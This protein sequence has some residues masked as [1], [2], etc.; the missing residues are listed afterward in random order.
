MTHEQFMTFSQST[1]MTGEIVKLTV[2]GAQI[3]NPIL[4]TA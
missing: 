3:P 4:N 1:G 2:T